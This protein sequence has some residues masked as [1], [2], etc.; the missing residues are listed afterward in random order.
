MYANK[1]LRF[2]C[3]LQNTTAEDLKRQFVLK[4]SLSDGTISIFE[5]PVRNSGIQGGR[6]LSPQLIVKPGG[7]RDIPEYYT[8]KDFFIGTLILC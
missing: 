1:Y 3:I 4:F 6:F 7:N 8:S 2:G 5:P